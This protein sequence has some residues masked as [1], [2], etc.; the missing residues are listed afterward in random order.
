MWGT[1]VLEDRRPLH[2]R[3]IPTHVGNTARLCAQSNATR[4]HPH[5]CGEHRPYTLIVRQSGGSSPRMW[6]TP[7]LCKVNLIL[8]RF[9]P[10]HVGNTGDPAALSQMRSVHPHACGEHIVVSRI[11]SSTTGS[12]PRMWGTLTVAGYSSQLHR[13]I[14]THVGNTVVYRMVFISITVHPHACGEHEY[15]TPDP[16]SVPGSSPR[17][18]GTRIRPS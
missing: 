8:S 10:T 18:W 15:I 1:R 7:Y 2:V 16:R 6:G 3:F 11:F 17:M 12:S 5:A 13:F 4:V 9:I 14:P